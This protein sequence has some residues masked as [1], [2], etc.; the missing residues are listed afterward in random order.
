MD[1]DVPSKDWGWW[2]KE[3]RTKTGL[4]QERVAELSGLSVRAI[5]DIERGRTRS[6]R[7]G[8]LIRLAEAL[9]LH[10]GQREEFVAS[11][12]KRISPVVAVQEI[13]PQQLPASASGFVGRRAYLTALTHLLDPVDGTA[14]VAIIDGTAGA[15][16]TTLAV[17]WA[18]SASS[19][20][21]DGQMFVDLL[22]FSPS[23]SPLTPAD[24]VQALLDGLGVPPDRCPP[25][26]EA[27]LGVYRSLL[28]GRR[29]L[30]VLDNARDAEQVRPLLP[31]GGTCRTIV[32]S[33]NRLAGLVARDGAAAVT[34]GV[35][36]DAEARDLLERRLGAG[37]L[38]TSPDAVVQITEQC[39]GLPLAL[40]VAAARAALR[41]EVPLATVAADLASHQRLATLSVHGDALADVRAAFSW[42]YRNLPERTR[43]LFRLLGLNP[44]ADIS[45]AAAVALGADPASDLDE[46]AHS[47]LLAEHVPGRFA[48]HDLL[49]AYAIELNAAHDTPEESEAA[50]IRLLSYY[51]ETANAAMDVAFPG[52]DH[53]WPRTHQHPP[54]PAHPSDPPTTRPSGRP[55]DRPPGRPDA[56]P[57]ADP[58]TARAWLDAERANMVASIAALADACP[59]HAV[60]LAA[61]LF[62]YMDVGGH[63]NEAITIYRHAQRAA[64]AAGDRAGEAM[65]LTCLGLTDRR[66]GRLAD[67]A[68]RLEQALALFRS[69]GDRAGE[70]RT[71]AGLGLLDVEGA[72]FVRAADRLRTALCLLREIGDRFAEARVLGNLGGAERRLGN[73]EQ[74]RAHLLESLELCREIGD[75]DGEADAHT[76][77]GRIEI[78]RERHRE[79]VSRARRALDLCREVGD[80]LGEGDAL[81]VLAQS[82]A[83]EGLHRRARKAFGQVIEVARQVGDRLNESEALCGI[84]LIDLHE[85]RH[86]HAVTGAGRAL[87]LAQG[88]GCRIRET[89]AFTCLG[90]AFLAMDR[91]GQA[92]EHFSVALDLAEQIGE[93]EKQA[94]AHHGLARAHRAAGEPKRAAPQWQQALSLYTHLGSPKSTQIQTEPPSAPPDRRTLGPKPPSNS[95]AGA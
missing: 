34:L 32:T 50:S 74:A 2:V 37:R 80:V 22:G 47:H 64:R 33:R 67:A 25:S 70:G 76:R 12:R 72:R 8:T 23:G 75:R 85:G 21:P 13:V 7:P 30:L 54:A 94:H 39:A 73:Y 42:S 90:E 27:R 16:K 77:I 43:R 15:G 86:D 14:S 19:R 61:V 40:S 79:A 71:L 44:G 81:L 17:H 38:A 26:T 36:S 29:M 57:I 84:A 49:R 95:V 65:M 5:S 69:V 31:P 88:A 87:D 35:M 89:G 82:Y 58:V 46:L 51:L 52:R 92:I 62:D 1:D 18:H 41:P 78:V 20:F 63:L 55:S 28:A 93:R 59:D 24:A 83:S 6:P 91:P 68:D 53:R 10:A 66:R 9:G 60:S 11:A 45:R 56:R 4:S 48:F 3:V